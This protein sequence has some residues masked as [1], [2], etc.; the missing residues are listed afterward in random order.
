MPIP[1]SFHT[2]NTSGKWQVE[3]PHFKRSKEQSPIT[4]SSSFS[5][6]WI[7]TES[8]LLQSSN[9]ISHEGKLVAPK[10][11]H[12]IPRVNPRF[13]QIIEQYPGSVTQLQYTTKLIKKKT[14]WHTFQRGRNSMY[15]RRNTLPHSS[16]WV[17]QTWFLHAVARI[18]PNSSKGKV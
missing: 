17:L 14:R 1:L 5:S 13:M 7:P 10:M 4:I 16:L 2:H 9:I 3:P 11:I 18:S 8:V 6:R 12:I 15:K